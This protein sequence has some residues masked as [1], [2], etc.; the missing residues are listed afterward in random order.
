MPIGGE[1]GI[2]KGDVWAF[3]ERKSFP[4]VAAQIINQPAHYDSSITIR[5]VQDLPRG[6]INTRRYKLPCKWAD[7]EEYLEAH[8]DVPRELPRPDPNRI[9]PDHEFDPI[10]VAAV[11]LFSIGQSAL[12]RII[13]EELDRSVA[14]PRISLNYDDAA[15]AVGVSRSTLKMAVARGDLTPSYQNTKPLFLISEL[16]RWVE[17]LPNDA[18]E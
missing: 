6:L 16:Q 18:P 1:L 14:V 12:R 8:P 11:D 13:R 3:R 10:D 17:S 4:L 15:K 5:L 7:V 9:V 2:R